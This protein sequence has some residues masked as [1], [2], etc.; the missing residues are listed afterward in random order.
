MDLR[1]GWFKIGYFFI[2]KMVGWF[3]IDYFFL[4]KGWQGEKYTNFFMSYNYVANYVLGILMNTRLF[5]FFSI[6][7]KEI[8]NKKSYVQRYIYA[9]KNKTHILYTIIT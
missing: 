8:R 6:I 9:K 2:G 7:L 3:I 4:G 5:L 1:V